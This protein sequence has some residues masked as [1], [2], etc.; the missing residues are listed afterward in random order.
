MTTIHV[1]LVALAALGISFTVALLKTAAKRGELKVDLESIGLGFVTNF[2]DTLG[3]GSFAPT[4]AWI[5]FRRLF[6][7]VSSR[8]P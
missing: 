8:G 5:K 4:T 1:L 3:I 2:F 7:T 6:P